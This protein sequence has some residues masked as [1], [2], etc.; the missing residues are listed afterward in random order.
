MLPT[1]LFHHA[2]SSSSYINVFKAKL[3]SGESPLRPL[4]HLLPF[5]VTAAIQIFWLSAP[6]YSRSAII[7]SPLFLPFLCTWGL[8]FAHQVGRMILAHLTKQPFPPGDALWL[9]SVLGAI[10]ANMPLLFGR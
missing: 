2:K 8:Q 7:E 10:D 1:L 9:M 3:A 5:P 6:H 4:L